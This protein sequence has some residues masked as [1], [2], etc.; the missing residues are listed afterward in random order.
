MLLATPT[1]VGGA[2][3]QADSGGESGILS[4]TIDWARSVGS[5]VYQSAQGVADRL[6]YGAAHAVGLGS[7]ETASDTVDA[8]RDYADDGDREDSI[9]TY[10]NAHLPEN[11]SPTDY[12]VLRLDLEAGDEQRT[13]YAVSTVSD[14]NVTDVAVVDSTDR[15]V[16]YT[17][18]FDEFATRELP[19]DVAWVYEKYVEPDEEPD[20]GLTARFTAKYP[21]H[22]EVTEGSA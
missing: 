15:T 16:D 11:A 8:L 13:V 2:A 1:V 3:A 5:S 22:V 4:S 6:S 7:E 12:D 17:L 14:G 21:G 20:A 19:S 18:V 10:A 9:V